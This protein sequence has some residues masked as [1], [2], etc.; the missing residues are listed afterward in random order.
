MIRKALEPSL[1][2]VPQTILG[3]VSRSVVHAKVVCTESGVVAGIEALE[4]QAKTLGLRIATYVS[5]GARVPP[6]SIVALVAGNP[7]QVVRG[8][9]SLLGTVAKVSG[10]ATAA[11]TA[12][13]K[14][15]RL[16]VV[17]GGWK[18]MPASMKDQLRDALRAGGL[19]AR[20]APDPF[21]Y[22]DKNY[23]RILGSIVA[24]MESAARLPGRT[25]AIQLRG[26]TAPISEEAIAAARCGAHILMVDT[27]RI[28]DLRA[29]STV[30]TQEGLRSEVEIAFAGNLT[31][32]DL[33]RLQ[34]EDTDVVDIGRAIL[35]APLLDFRYDVFDIRVCEDG[36]S[37][38]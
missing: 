26:E 38:S 25:V 28:D 5:S 13:S 16:R 18:K 15:G 24:A 2:D 3:D 35:D 8:E 10:V 33:E 29:V 4:H 34:R 27:G 11:H 6:G 1:V 37:P 36:L 14:A 12:R 22:L 21:L 32:G 30:L 19:D 31:L 23:I 17:C 20:I 7:V 9:D